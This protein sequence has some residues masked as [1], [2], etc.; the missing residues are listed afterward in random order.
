MQLYQSNTEAVKSEIGTFV[1]VFPQHVVWGNPNDGQGYDLVLTG[2]VEPITI[3]VDA[4]QARLDSPPYAEVARSLREIGIASAVDLL[5]SYAGSAADL[6]PWLAD[7][8]INRDRN[9]R[10]QYL[11]GMGMNQYRSG[12]IYAEMLQHAKFPGALFTGSPASMQALRDA[13][14]RGVGR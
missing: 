13:I 9:L 10:L 5:S 8:A 2:Q 12:P 4:M 14:E 3:D 7:A 6:A 1:E 11:A